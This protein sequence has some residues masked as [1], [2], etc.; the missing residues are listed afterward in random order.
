M[1]ITM[2][3]WSCHAAT[4][5]CSLNHTQRR[6]TCNFG[7]TS[8]GADADASPC[9]PGEALP[10]A[11]ANCTARLR[12]RVASMAEKWHQPMTSPIIIAM[13]GGRHAALTART[14]CARC[15]RAKLLTANGVGFAAALGSMLPVILSGN[16]G[17]V[18]SGG[19]PSRRRCP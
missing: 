10:L 5:R 19:T 3:A 8:C 1:V 15:A 7:L 2:S 6:R 17:S 9:P 12:S 18:A 4:W 13:A 14:C 11:R 16:I